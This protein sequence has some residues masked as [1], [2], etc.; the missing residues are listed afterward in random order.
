MSGGR[1]I[2]G[3]AIRYKPD[4]FGLYNIPLEKRGARFEEGLQLM[5]LL[6]AEQAVTF[7]G[8]YYQAD[9]VR[10]EPRPVST[11][12]PS[13]WIGGWGKL[14]LKRDATFPRKART[15]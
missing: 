12:H 4:E 7:K 9:D 3:T 14:A 11:P 1:F 2:F 13:V 15:T 6:W 8:R 10:I 5:K